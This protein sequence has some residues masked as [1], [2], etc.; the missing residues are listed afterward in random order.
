[1]EVRGRNL[2]TGYPATLQINSTEML[3]ALEE[4]VGQVFDAIHSVL[5]QTPPDVGIPRGS[6]AEVVTAVVVLEEGATFDED[7]ARAT[8]REHLAEY[9]RP[10]TYVVWEELP[11]SLIGKVLRRKVRDTLIADRKAT[12]AAE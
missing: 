3:E 9:K 12:R 6:G 5:E 1:M 7:A 2:A 11:T 4:P 10:T 8:A